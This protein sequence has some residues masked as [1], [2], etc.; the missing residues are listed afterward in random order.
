MR[1][2]YRAVSPDTGDHFFLVLPYCKTDCM[3]IFLKELAAAYPDNDI[4]L[5]C[6]NA[7]WHKSKGLEVP[8]N[9]TILHIPPYTPE[10][11]PIEQIWAELRKRGFTNCVFQT[12]EKVVDRLCDIIN[13]LTL[14]DVK[15]ITHRDWLIRPSLELE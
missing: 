15:S 6:D 9:I 2:A 14:T 4:I 1:Y 10:M 5:I 11:N 7:V 8:D 13:T 3:N 12:L